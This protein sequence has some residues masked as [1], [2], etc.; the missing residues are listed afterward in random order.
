[1]KLLKKE[2]GS[3]F[4]F[5]TLMIVLLMIMVGMGLDTGWLTYVR[6]QGQPAV[7]AAALAGATAV[8]T[9]DPVEVE[10]RVEAFN[11]T[12][13]FA[14]SVDPNNRIDGTPG[15]ANVTYISYN[16]ATGTVTDVPTIAAANGIRVALENQ[17]PYT[18]AT[19]NSPITAPVF[20]TPL[21]N[22]L[23]FS[24]PSTADVNV[25]AVAAVQAV[26]GLPIVLG[27]CPMPNPPAP[28]P[29]VCTEN[30]VSDSCTTVNGITTCTGCTLLK[31]PATK[32]N[33]GYTSYWFGSANAS[34][35]RAMVRNNFTC[36]S[37]P[38]VTTTTDCILLNN[39][40]INS[41]RK[42]IDDA[43]KPFSDPNPDP[44]DCFII[45]V[46]D[47]NTNFNQCEVI[48]KFAKICIREVKDSGNPKFVKVNLTC[49]VS[50]VN[51]KDA[52]C[53]IPKLV[54]DT[55]SGM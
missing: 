54:R 44:N 28:E 9:G 35:M 29:P 48:Q 8:P 20:L 50:I 2:S 53:Y 4:V 23:G 42:E 36:D 38:A 49:P 21:F 37:I 5:V 14:G 31:S 41:V 46:V 24:M 47:S 45:P 15:Q 17:N 33:A 40:N 22:L 52:K 27:G 1:M 10:K 43:F 13:D 12:N 16:P 51:T 6:S 39:G 55:Q 18:G 34:L 32:D 11:A 25:S 30:G 19:S 7:D 26:P 3:V